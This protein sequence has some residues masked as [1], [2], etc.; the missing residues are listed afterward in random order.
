MKTIRSFIL[1]CISFIVLATLIWFIKAYKT[2]PAF[3]ANKSILKNEEGI[4]IKISDFKG[5]YILLS[6]FQT[7][8]G[9]CIQELE[10][11]D[12]L[13]MKVGKDKL[14]VMMVSDEPWKKIARFKEK[15][16]N[17]LDYYQSVETL[18]SQNIRVFPTTYLL[19]KDGNVLIS[20]IH[21]FDWSSDEA[22]Q[23]IK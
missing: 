4:T 1:I 9:D 20:K 17:T 6:Y 5:Q 21:S 19:D 10:D 22:L 2:P 12:A 14:K 23:Q 3:R 8:C 13:Q 15:H 7:W 16:C 18:N 11:I